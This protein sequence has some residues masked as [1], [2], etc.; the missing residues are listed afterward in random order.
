MVGKYLMMVLGCS[1]LA[2]CSSFQPGESVTP[3]AEKLVEWLKF[4]GTVYQVP[5][6][7]STKQLDKSHQIDKTYY[8]KDLRCDD[9]VKRCTY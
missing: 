2:G 7:Y 5:D 1:L 4:G 6:Y 9:H 8:V 3:E